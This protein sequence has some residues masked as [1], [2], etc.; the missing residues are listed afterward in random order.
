MYITKLELEPLQ[1]VHS[2]NKYKKNNWTD[3]FSATS[4]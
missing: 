1:Y 4:Y 3:A 2:K